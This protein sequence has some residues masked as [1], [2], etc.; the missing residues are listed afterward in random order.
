MY[1]SDTGYGYTFALHP[2]E[3]SKMSAPLM[4][5]ASIAGSRLASC[6]PR[7]TFASAYSCPSRIP[8]SCGYPP[9]RHVEVPTFTTADERA[10][11]VEVQVRKRPDHICACACL[12][13]TLRRTESRLSGSEGDQDERS[14][15]QGLH[16]TETDAGAEPIVP[17]VFLVRSSKRRIPD[18]H[19]SGYRQTDRRQSQ[20][21]P[22]SPSQSP[23]NGCRPN[24]GPPT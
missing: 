21:E 8:K 12:N 17:H 23:M 20:H 22:C 3:V 10:A 13:R 1:W 14:E 24:I 6:V 9:S 18:A 16:Q 7:L 2:S 19:S 4:R 11:S 5:G 15:Q